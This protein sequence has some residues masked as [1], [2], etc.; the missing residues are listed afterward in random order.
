MDDLLGG[1]VE[2]ALRADGQTEHVFL[3]H[4]HEP[5]ATETQHCVTCVGEQVRVSRCEAGC[6]VIGQSVAGPGVSENEA[7]CL[8]EMKDGMIG[9]RCAAN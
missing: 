2:S 5:V 1:G 6:R 8:K 9:N 7:V 4:F 3:P